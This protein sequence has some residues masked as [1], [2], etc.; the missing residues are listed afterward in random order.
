MN[1]E[2]KMTKSYVEIRGNQCYGNCCTIADL[3][4]KNLDPDKY[5]V[6]IEKAECSKCGKR[7]ASLDNKRWR[8][9]LKLKAHGYS[10][11]EVVLEVV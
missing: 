3:D 6:I 7:W 5:T 11:D 4:R 1:K 10:E 8:H 2:T 9:R